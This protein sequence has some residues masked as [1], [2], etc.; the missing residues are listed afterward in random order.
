MNRPE[1]YTLILDQADASTIGKL[2][3]KLLEQPA[4]GVDV[5]RV[6]QQLLD[7]R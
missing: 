5:S 1:Q 2:T 7:L 3:R 4:K 6:T